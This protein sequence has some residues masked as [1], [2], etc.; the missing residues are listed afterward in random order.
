ML[1]VSVPP[2]L[3]RGETAALAC[4]YELGS[5]RLYSVTWYKDHDEIYRYVPR[6]ATQK[7]SYL[8]DGVHVEVSP[9]NHSIR[10]RAG[11]KSTPIS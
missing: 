8:V 7:H 9:G 11:K 3:L 4:E 6:A 10:A 5:D 2:V 1:R